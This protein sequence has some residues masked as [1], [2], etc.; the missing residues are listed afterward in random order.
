VA[1]TDRLCQIGALDPHD[2]RSRTQDRLVARNWVTR[3]GGRALVATP[4]GREGLRCSLDLDVITLAPR[5]ARTQVWAS[6][7]SEATITAGRSTFAYLLLEL[8]FPHLPPANGPFY[9]APAA[10][11]PLR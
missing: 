2:S 9:L 6:E 8:L 5:P 11:A 10:K 4:I 7:R 3:R 1:I